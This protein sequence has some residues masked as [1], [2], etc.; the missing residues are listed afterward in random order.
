MRRINAKVIA[1]GL[2]TA[3]FLLAL[4]AVVAASISAGDSSPP[5][6]HP[7]HRTAKV[8]KV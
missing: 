6:A 1:V 3:G 2:L 7:A 4:A 5:P 8:Q